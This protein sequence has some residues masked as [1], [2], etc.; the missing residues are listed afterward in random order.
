MVDFVLGKHA[1]ISVS[2][3]RTIFLTCFVVANIL[4]IV[5][6]PTSDKNQFCRQ[7]LF[8]LGW[9]FSWKKT[10]FSIHRQK[11][12][13]PAYT[14]PDIGLTYTERILQIGYVAGARLNRRG[15]S[16]VVFVEIAV[17]VK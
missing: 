3:C 2:I 14:T 13:N 9:F 16:W 10:G 8:L 1:Q 4:L 15:V 7:K 11:L 6:L 17:M 12:A 5:I